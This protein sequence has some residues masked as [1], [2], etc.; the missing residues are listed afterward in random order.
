M[1]ISVSP[2]QADFLLAEMTW[3]MTPEI[4]S[5]FVVWKGRVRDGQGVSRPLAKTL[6]GQAR[7]ASSAHQDIKRCVETHLEPTLGIL[8]KRPQEA[9]LEDGGGKRVRDDHEP[10][11]GIGQRLHLEETDLIET[12]RV[13]VDGVAVQRCTLRKALV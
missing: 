2:T 5:S 7:Q 8:S 10:V 6:H 1:P 12:P 13:N 3:P 4:L 11:G 9:L